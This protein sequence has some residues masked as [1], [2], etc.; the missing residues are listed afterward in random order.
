MWDQTHVVPPWARP[1]DGRPGGRGVQCCCRGRRGLPAVSHVGQGLPGTQVKDAVACEAD[2]VCLPAWGIHTLLARGPGR[3]AGRVPGPGPPWVGEPLPVPMPGGGGSVW[4]SEPPVGSNTSSCLISNT[5]PAP[6][7]AGR[8]ARHRYRG[9]R[10]VARG[11][12]PVQPHRRRS[13]CQLRSCR[14]CLS[15]RVCFSSSPDGRGPPP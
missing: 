5:D 2:A 15:R 9:D 6:G 8:G 3:G 12:G 4:P 1:G 11:L 7:P 14:P 10:K 13:S